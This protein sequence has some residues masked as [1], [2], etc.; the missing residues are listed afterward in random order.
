MRSVSRHS[1][2]GNPVFARAALG[3]DDDQLNVTDERRGAW[4][5]DI[6]T[7]AGGPH[8][9]LP[10]FDRVMAEERRVA[11]LVTPEREHCNG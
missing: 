10:T 6:F 1:L 8:D 2:R 4:I 3:P 7:A 5:G 11:V 9:D